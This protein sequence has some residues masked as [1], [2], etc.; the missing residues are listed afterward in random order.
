ML[1]RGWMRFG[2]IGAMMLALAAGCAQEEEAP[3]AGDEFGVVGGE[4]DEEG[5]PALGG[6]GWKGEGGKE[7]AAQG[8]LGLPTT[9]DTSTTQV[10]EIKNQW[11]DKDTAAA[12]KAGM[13]WGADSGLTWED[14]Y[15]LWI[16]SFKQIDRAGSYG[17][18][19]EMTTPWGRTVPAPSLECAESSMFLRVAFASWYNLPFYMEAVDGTK[20][21]VYFGHFGVRTAT[22]RYGRTPEYKVVYKDHTAQADKI[23]RGELAW[24][25]DA[26]LVGRKIPGS[27]DDAQPAI[28]PNAHAGAYFDQV[29]LNK[30]VGYF[31]MLQLTYFGSI[32]MADPA[33]T[34]NVKAEA[35]QPGDSLVER[36]QKTGIGHVLVV[37]R[38]NRLEPKETEAGVVP[39]IEAELASGSM[40]RRQPVWEDG[41][42]SKRYFSLD[43]TG[44]PGYVEFGGGLKRWR[45]PVKLNGKWSNMVLPQDREAFITTTDKAALQARPARFEEVL[46]EVSLEEKIAALT[47]AIEAKR[48]HLRQYPAS[49]SAR[50]GREQLF[51]DLYEL[52]EAD[53]SD[54]A[55]I[56][57][58]HRLP[59]DYVFAEL[60]YNKSKNCCWN[61]TTAAMYEI[62]IAA[63]EA[64]L[65]DGAPECKAPLVFMN[66]HDGADGYKVFKDF[67]VSIGRGAEWREWRADEGCPQ[68]EFAEA[69]EAEHVWTP[70]CELN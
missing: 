36:W 33:N 31:L 19:Y 42:S 26:T 9:V 37:M 10:W 66:R 39:Q 14:K 59:E 64:H 55:A 16:A 54:R 51:G 34:F 30:R 28:G 38:A 62:A 24:P 18:T 15:R 20:T 13:A 61:S 41:A 49:C 70:W 47:N 60:V 43:E 50:T 29:F 25:V 2:V 6:S 69:A 8:R 65:A 44:G 45:S 57:K 48:K 11:A 58:E 5:K 53:G 12:K 32:S 63:N 35:V 4:V 46:S 68:V 23:M 3:E 56:D 27:Y 21:R 1:A 22:G 17:K 7:D 52:L 67:A 40:P